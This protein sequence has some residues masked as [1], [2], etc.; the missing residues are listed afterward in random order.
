MA[1]KSVTRRNALRIGAVL[2]AGLALS[3][4]STPTTQH[5]DHTESVSN[6]PTSN[7]KIFRFAQAAQVK[8]LDPAA[9]TRIESHRI[10]AQILEPLVGADI[11]TGEPV[12]ALAESWDI[13]TDGRTYTFTLAHDIVFSDGTPL[14][15]DSI[16]RNF[17]RWKARGTAPITRTNQAYARLFAESPNLSEKPTPALI[18]SW[19][20][21]DDTTFT[22]TLSR[23][24]TS[25]L[26]ALTQP[27]CGIIQPKQ[28]TPDDSP[29]QA[30]IGSGAF[31]L[32]SWD[33][34]T[35]VLHRS[36][37][38]R[39]TNPDIDRLEFVT[40]P[41]AEKRYYNLV[42]GFIDAY[43]QV[44]L[45]D[46]VPLAL[47]GYA[48]Q[49]RDPYA[50][51]YIGINLSH[52]AFDDARVR[53]ALACAIDRAAIIGAYYPQ[54]TKMASD[55]IP[56]LFQMKN[57]EAGEI[58]NYSAEKAKE[59][60]RSSTYANQP[61]DFYYPINLSIP[62]LPSPEGI[63]SLISTNLVSAGFNIVPKPYKWSDDG[64]DDIPAAHPDYGLELNGFIGAYRDP[65]AFLGQ[66]LAPAASAPAEIG[67]TSGSSA[68]DLST[69]LNEIAPTID[70]AKTV[71]SYASIMQ[72]ITE[73]D[74]ITGIS[75][76]RNA[77]RK[78]N[79]QVSDFLPAIPL[80]YP[81]SGV[82]Q[83]ARV[84]SYTVAATCLDVFSTVSVDS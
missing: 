74:T 52:T 29:V 21:Q 47:D 33:G 54:G 41:G 27:A 12:P 78:L 26:K 2:S 50:I 36:E 60:L 38:Y 53:Q 34:A 17:D 42:E 7:E 30:P 13:S 44:A 31:T 62:S 67:F 32:K 69:S 79:A 15:A 14:T 39:G 81:V 37:N 57:A 40:I 8:H 28:F 18:S 65:T 58:Y 82:T 83:G 11:N 55:F 76:W 61:I 48:V 3:A 80:A 84:N 49:S 24:S 64:S 70:P 35:A 23:R 63:Y 45:K 73:A 68:N 16:S 66:V 22:V 19:K 77:Y 10:S 20:A 56:A 43:D 72:A 46:Y 6:S 59:L 1:A 5:P 9:T 25:F 75:E 4:C 51:A 71:S